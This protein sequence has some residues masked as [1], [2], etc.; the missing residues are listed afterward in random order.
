MSVEHRNDYKNNFDGKLIFLSNSNDSTYIMAVKI[1]KSLKEATISDHKKR[2]LI[3]FEM[4]FEYQH[5]EDLNQLSNSRLYTGLRSV[6]R[7]SNKNA[8]EDFKF[9][10]DTINNET[11]V[12]IKR[13][14]NSKRKKTIF[15]HYYFF[16]K[17]S[18]VYDAKKNSIKNYLIDKYNL[19]LNAF[20]LE[21]VY[22]LE[23]GKLAMKSEDIQNESIDFNFN[24]KI[25]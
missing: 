4:D 10:R 6:R 16:G 19:D 9:E 5:I 12:H 18:N 21:K 23:D 2:W 24:F 8:V 15:D 20:N 22:H 11:I 1:G 3:K 7:K 25:D 14:K 17:K 13:F